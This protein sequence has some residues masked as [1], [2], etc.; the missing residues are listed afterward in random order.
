MFAFFVNGTKHSVDVDPDMPLLW[1]LRDILGM[2]GTKFGC[3]EGYCGSCTVL[4]DQEPIR[5][6]S[7]AISEVQNKHIHTIEGLSKQHAKL[8]KNW[9]ELNVSQCGYCQPGQLMT[10]AALLNSN[11]HP[12]EAEIEDAMSGNI[13]RCGTYQRIKEALV[14]T[15]ESD[16]S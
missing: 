6:C 1:V 10:A 11:P 15:A 2:T 9:E 12:T 16:K 13:C 7:T 4:L 5:S 8:Q 14:K 3:G